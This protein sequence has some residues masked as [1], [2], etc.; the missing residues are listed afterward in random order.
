ML[1]LRLWKLFRKVFRIFIETSREHCRNVEPIF[2]N[3]QTTLE[4]HASTFFFRNLQETSQQQVF[5]NHYKKTCFYIVIETLTNII[6]P[7]FFLNAEPLLRNMFVHCFRKRK[8][9]IANTSLF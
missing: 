2:L 1:L 9:D 6:E 8:S 7:R 5:F 3:G 4:K